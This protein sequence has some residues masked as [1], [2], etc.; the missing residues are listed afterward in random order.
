MFLDQRKAEI[1][2][3]VL[4]ISDRFWLSRQDHQALEHPCPVQVHH[5][6]GG[7]L[8]LGVLRSVLAQQLEP[9]HRFM[10]MGQIRQ[11]ENSS[12]YFLIVFK[13]ISSSASLI[14][15]NLC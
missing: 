1:N 15:K 10:R 7:S 8:R 2:I 3:S 12:N 5:P 6:G 13:E 9:H 14:I 4:T 11:G